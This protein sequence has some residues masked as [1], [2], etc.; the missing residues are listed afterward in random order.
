MYSLDL[1]YR[2]TPSRRA[3]SEITANTES[4]WKRFL[5]M[6]QNS[7]DEMLENSKDLDDA[8]YKYFHLMAEKKL[9]KSTFSVYKSGL[10]LKINDL[11]NGKFDTSDAKQFPM[12]YVSIS[13]LLVLKL[14]STRIVFDPDFESRI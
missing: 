10:K 12:F 6:S 2:N 13:L 1:L 8:L 5:K 7:L 11:S 14:I 9:S 4:I 3:S